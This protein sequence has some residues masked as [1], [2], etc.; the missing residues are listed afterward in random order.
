M[1]TGFGTAQHIFAA[2]VVKSSNDGVWIAG[3]PEKANIITVGQGF[4]RDGE[5]VA[6]VD[7]S[8]D[9]RVMTAESP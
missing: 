7:E 4:V 8:L 5:R 3:L 9:E 2:D 1:H 6:A